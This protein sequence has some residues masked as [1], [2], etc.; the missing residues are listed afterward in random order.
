M[1]TTHTTPGL[2]L[3][4]ISTTPHVVTIQS[5]DR[6]IIQGNLYRA[7]LDGETR[8]SIDSLRLIGRLPLRGLVLILSPTTSCNQ[9]FRLG[10]RWA[11]DSVLI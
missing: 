10:L 3:L 5:Q 8:R 9:L 6:N 1:Y 2:W 11:T 7:A 4:P